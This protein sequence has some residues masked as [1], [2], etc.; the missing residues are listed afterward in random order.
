MAERS[1]IKKAGDFFLRLLKPYPTCIH[2]QAEESLALG[3]SAI[4]SSFKFGT[5]YNQAEGSQQ[6]RYKRCFSHLGD[7]G[8][9]TRCEII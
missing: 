4:V 2:T 6:G 1:V 8:F 3:G 9:E 7:I 5:C